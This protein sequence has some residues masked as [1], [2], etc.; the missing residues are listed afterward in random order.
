MIEQIGVKNVLFETD[1]PHPTCPYPRSQEH[2]ANVLGDLDPEVR[3]AVLQ[4]SASEL[5][6]I[7]VRG[8]HTRLS[9]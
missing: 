2:I 1:L 8:R 9:A 3:S 6:R 5:Y 7:P 4:E